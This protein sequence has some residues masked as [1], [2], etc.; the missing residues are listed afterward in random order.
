MAFSTVLT[1]VIIPIFY[2]SLE[3]YYKVYAYV[4]LMLVLGVAIHQ[5]VAQGLLPYIG[6]D[7]V[8]T[9]LWNETLQ[10][11]FLAIWFL[12]ILITGIRKFLKLEAQYE[13][14]ALVAA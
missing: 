1:L 6:S 9:G 5:G 13:N 8:F 4:I 3:L 10:Y 14:E 12:L 11:I 2:Y 7:S